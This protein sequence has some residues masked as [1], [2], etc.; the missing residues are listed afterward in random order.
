MNNLTEF[1]LFI[2][3]YQKQISVIS[4][5]EHWI[6]NSNIYLLNK[7][8]NY[9]IGDY[10]AREH[11]ARGGSCLLIKSNIKFKI[12]NDLKILN[13]PNAFEGSFIE[14]PEHNSI[15]VSIY[16]VP[17][18]EISKIFLEKFENLLQKLEKEAKVKNI[19]IAS[20]VNINVLQNYQSSADLIEIC[21]SY[22]FN[23]NVMEPTRITNH[24]ST[25]IDN[26]FSN[27][28][29]S[30]YTNTEVID[31]GV[32]D[33]KALLLYNNFGCISS[34]ATYQLVKEKTRIFSKRN[35]EKFK[36]L[37]KDFKCT[38]DQRLN[39]NENYNNFL[40]LFLN[41]FN[42][43]YPKVLC[44]SNFSH[45]PKNWVTQGIKI[46]AERKR[47]LHC[48]SK[49]NRSPQFL[50]YFKNYNKIFK[51]VVTLAKLKSNDNFI[52]KCE[53]KSK[54]TWTIVKNELGLRKQKS[55]TP[56]EISHNFRGN[57]NQTVKSTADYFNNYFT[58]IAKQ[59]NN[60]ANT[61][62]ALSYI[63]DV[64]G[65][66][67]KF[68]HV[69]SNELKK[70]VFNLKNKNSVGWDEVP[71]SIIKG[72]FDVI[73]EPLCKIINQSL[74]QGSFPDKLK[75]AEIKPL[76]KKGNVN[77]PSSYRPI[78]LLSCFSKILEKVVE[79]QVSQFLESNK[80]LSQT[81]YGFRKGHS[82]SKAISDLVDC[83]SGALDKSNRTIGVL[84]DLS[85]AFDC[86]NH[87]ILISKLEKIGIHNLELNWFASY[88][89]GRK[90]RIVINKYHRNYRSNWMN[91]NYGVPQGSILG[92][93]LFIIY[94]N[95]LSSMT[96]MNMYQYADDTT[97]IC[98]DSLRSNTQK[99]VQELKS[100]EDWCGVN[101]LTMNVSKTQLI[102][103]QTVNTTSQPSVNSN[104]TNIVFQDCINFLGLE[105]DSKL[106]WNIHLRNLKKK[107]SSI[108]FNLRILKPTTT[109][110]TQLIVYH[111]YFSAHLTYGI[112]AWGSSSQA[113]SVFKVQKRA[114][115]ILAGVS[116]RTHC[117]D[118][119]VQ[120]KILTIFSH[121][122]L[123]AACWAKLNLFTLM[124]KQTEHN[125]NTRHKTLIKP[126]QHRLK[127]FEQSP[128]YMAP[129]IYNKLPSEFKEINCILKFKSTLKKWLE[130]KA[131]YSLSEYLE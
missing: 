48:E 53:N 20:D 16:R 91:I 122:I 66:N 4:L 105:I 35:L 76:F 63:K 50:S 125:Y 102:E 43:A 73:S 86:V 112:L 120:F 64:N 84:C 26:I 93:C 88:L 47:L 111:A 104:G 127:L 77:D 55:E 115:R 33:H 51:K 62:I 108:V 34:Q 85:K 128:Q 52:N 2:E 129:K 83:V 89:Q 14:V 98:T 69:S 60:S 68:S 7:L 110:K 97:L 30:T 15:Y 25:C 130:E 119:F 92:P 80:I 24:S 1:K 12:R 96:K 46:S 116:P 10:F 94:V 75:F 5:N 22:G 31:V 18:P 21:N 42:E 79:K 54:A 49:W 28:K 38:F 113:I 37:M 8:D 107:L 126:I 39:V 17:G 67:F 57:I 29:T 131:F 117:R 103:F 106:N 19:F 45:K 58:N 101:G 124:E 23:I 74:K 41:F 81:Q 9:S 100:L 118:F 99:V 78:A 121:F 59:S 95:E 3:N 65:L 87:E 44:N 11:N 61:K 36:L 13:V 40:S 114:V 90:Q 27:F 32:S 56:F 123:E 82:A 6:Q 72:V 71:I 109:L 70:I